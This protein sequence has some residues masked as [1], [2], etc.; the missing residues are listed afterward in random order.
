ME[1][2]RRG[3]ADIKDVSSAAEATSRLLVGN[4]FAYCASKVRYQRAG[5][6]VGYLYNQPYF[7][8][9]HLAH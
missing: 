6:P 9:T 4:I 2:L 8:L 7:H 3:S 5:R 1:G